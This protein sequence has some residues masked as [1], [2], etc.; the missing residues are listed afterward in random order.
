MTSDLTT[1]GLAQSPSRDIGSKETLVAAE[2]DANSC[3]VSVQYMI[4]YGLQVQFLETNI[5]IIS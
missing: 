4:I 1:E 3:G 2:D 5:F